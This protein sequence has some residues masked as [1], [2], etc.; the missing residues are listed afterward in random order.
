MSKP[1]AVIGTNDSHSKLQNAK[2]SNKSVMKEESSEMSCYFN[3]STTLS[4]LPKMMPNTNPSKQYEMKMDKLKKFVTLT[5]VNSQY[6]YWQQM[7]LTLCRQAEMWEPTLDWKKSLARC[8]SAAIELKLMWNLV[9]KKPNDLV[10]SIN[11]H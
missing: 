1:I 8:I 6:S 11:L 5:C 4:K 10:K 7:T 9:P 2:V 3:A